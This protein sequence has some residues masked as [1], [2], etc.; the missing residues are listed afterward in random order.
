MVNL[1]SLKSH[2]H[3]IGIG[4][5]GMSAIAL[6]LAK[7]GYSISGSDKNKSKAI[8]QLSEH[9][10]KIF[11]NQTESNIEELVKDNPKEILIVISSAIPK[12]NPELRKAIENKLQ[13]LHRSDILSSLTKEQPSILIAGSHGKTTTSTIVTTLLALC[14]KDPSAVIGGIMPFY[15]SNGHAGKGKYLVAEADESDGTLIKFQAEIGLITNLELDH[16]DFYKDIE[17]LQKIMKEFGN[18]C[19]SLIANYDCINLK[20]NFDSEINWYSINSFKGVD[21]SAIPEIF[22]GNETIAKYYEN[23]EFIGRITI[24]LPGL[25]NLSNALG[26]IAICRKAGIK[27][28]QLKEFL[29]QINTPKR[30][31]DFKGIWEGKQIIDDYAHHPSEI[32]ATI[33]MARLMINK[34]ESILPKEAKRLIVVF[35]PHRYSRTNTLMK[36]FAESFI[37][38]D[39]IFLLP[40]YSAGEPPIKGVSSESLS[41]LIKKKCPELAVKLT[42]D[43]ND[44]KV[45]LRELSQ[46]SD[47]ILFLGAG[48]ISKIA[49]DLTI[50]WKVNNNQ[51]KRQS[52]V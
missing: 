6:V 48:D 15:N 29:T 4:G 46:E 20:N 34:N 44:L 45:Q 23:E 7:R 12:N 32:K 38:S 10:V 30:R 49:E 28:D 39:Y 35:Q 13:I 52:N 22:N 33:S 50:E 43:F 3:F 42:N 9:G 17:S 36:D 19:R 5:I 40:I 1:N 31:F 47:L 16:T 41:R 25:H 51:I 8:T 18:N 14:Q 37:H 21:Y 2:I 27:F 11:T 24:P 26:A